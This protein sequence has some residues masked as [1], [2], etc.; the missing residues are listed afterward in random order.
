MNF[1]ACALYKNFNGLAIKDNFEE[2]IDDAS[3]QEGLANY[4]L[5]NENEEQI[6][7][8]DVENERYITVTEERLQLHA[9]S[10]TDLI[11]AMA[12]VEARCT[13]AVMYLAK[14]I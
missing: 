1:L 4:V 7:F 6:E 5:V 2:S 9:R 11:I 10:E 14:T 8:A 13:S 12:E 3:L